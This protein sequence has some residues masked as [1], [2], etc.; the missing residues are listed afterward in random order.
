MTRKTP[1]DFGSHDDWLAHVRGEIP[2]PEQAYVLALGRTDLF[3]GFYQTQGL[4][5]PT[6]FTEELERIGTLHDPERAT[7]LEVLNKAIFGSLTMH[8]FNRARPKTSQGDAVP[9]VSPRKRIG[10]LRSHLAQK[11]PYFALWVI[12]KRGASDQTITSE[13]DEYL[14][15]ELGIESAEEAAFTRAMAELDKLLDIF[16]DRNLSLPSLS[17]ERIWFLHYFRGPE[18]MAQAHA[19][20]GML[21]AELAACTSA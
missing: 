8:L 2:V 9:P 11:N 4:P 15:R 17:I 10:Q 13:W 1:S 12:Y 21:T 7:A 16:R 3:R 5:F 20:L 18:R 14:L 6:Q 19:V